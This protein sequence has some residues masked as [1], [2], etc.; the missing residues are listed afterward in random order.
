MNIV[1]IVE[2]KK[3]GKSLSKEEIDFIIY[4]LMSGKINEEKIV[5][6]FKE[7]N[8][9]NFSYEETYLLADAM[10][11]T[12]QM[13]DIK[14]DV[15]ECVDKHSAG[16]VSDASTLIFMSVLAALDVK[17][18]KGI[19]NDYGDF[20]NSLERL[21]FFDGFNSK[22]SRDKVIKILNNV[23]AAVFD[24]SEIVAPADIILY[25]LRK[26]FKLNSAPLV[27]ASILSKKIACGASIVVYD[28]KTGEGA[29]CP[30]AGY[31]QDMANYL[32]EA[33]KLAGIKAAAVI[34]DLNQPLC[35]AIGSKVELVEVVSAITTKEVKFDDG[36][37]A[38]ARELVIMALMLIG[39]ANGRSE[40]S[41]LFDQ[42]ILS[43]KALEKFKQFVSAYGGKFDK[44]I[45]FSPSIAN[46][47]AVSY[48]TAEDDGYITDIS[49]NG[50]VKGYNTLVYNKKFVDREAGI[51]LV[52]REGAKVVRGEKIVRIYY[53]LDN[54]NYTSARKLVLD[55]ITIGKTKSGASKILYKVVV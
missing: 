6:F 25:K 50:L 30:D 42:A 43:G 4:G 49:I 2:E 10:A 22:I 27:A 26:R 11:R 34:S 38:V 8:T 15:G 12:G 53:G 40:A 48:I 18:V 33:S 13:M 45:D 3:Q 31:S 51:V 47:V 1:E 55:S 37:L 14:K 9:Q 36:L 32:V 17:T 21:S 35:A 24:E 23:G 54:S 52:K 29:I 5:N 39:K 46:G 44:T 7:I 41:D 28:V 16:L 19:S 20:R